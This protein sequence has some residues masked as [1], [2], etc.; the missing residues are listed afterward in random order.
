MISSI[1]VCESTFDVLFR[2]VCFNSPKNVFIQFK[3]FS[4]NLTVV[5]F[6]YFTFY[7]LELQ[8][9]CLYLY[10]YI[11]MLNRFTFDSSYTLYIQADRTVPLVALVD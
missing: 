6:F 1:V 3:V 10:F 4:P 8:S 7:T 11:Y 9:Y 5:A 2:A